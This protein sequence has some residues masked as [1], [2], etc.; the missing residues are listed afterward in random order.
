MEKHMEIIEDI[1]KL[2]R[3]ISEPG[4]GVSLGIFDLMVSEMVGRGVQVD[5]AA[6]QA[7]RA[8]APNV[9]VVIEVD[10]ELEYISIDID[11]D[12]NVCTYC[13]PNCDT[14]LISEPEA[15]E[16]W[17]SNP[18][19]VNSN[20]LAKLRFIVQEGVKYYDEEDVYLIESRKEQARKDRYEQQ[21]QVSFSLP[22]EF[23]L[24]CEQ[25]EL[26]P[27][28]ALRGFIADVCGIESFI[29]HPTIPRR[30]DGYTSNGSDERDMARSYFD[31]TYWSPEVEEKHGIS[32]CRLY[33][34]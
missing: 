20:D 3:N 7:A 12:L 27:T 25:Y 15:L 32:Y 34:Y 11:G 28:Q 4:K 18:D 1:L 2:S 31:R 24:L 9:I 10:G 14:Q 22:D 23:L 30:T 5:Q 33:H 6:T 26:T 8:L 16:N 13:G 29:N 19:K 17:D 21:R